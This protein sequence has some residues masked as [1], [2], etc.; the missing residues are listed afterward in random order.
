M[1]VELALVPLVAIVSV[2]EGPAPAPDVVRH[3]GEGLQAAVRAAVARHGELVFRASESGLSVLVE[4]KRRSV[5]GQWVFGGA[6]ATTTRRPTS[7]MPLLFLART[8]GGRWVISLEG[9]R[10][11][12]TAVRNA[13]PRLLN[14]WESVVLAATHTG[15]GASTRLALPWR[16]GDSWRHS[17][18][19]GNSGDS[20]PFNAID[21]YGGDGRVRAAGP[22]LVYQFCTN[23]R[24]PYLKIV[25]PNGLVTGYYHLRDTTE[26]ADGAVVRAGEYLGRIGSE[27]PCGGHAT[28]DHVHWSLWRGGQPLA[29]HGRNIGGWTWYEGSVSYQGFARRG[30]ARVERGE[31]CVTNVGG[32]TA[33][34]S[35]DPLLCLPSRC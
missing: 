27:V 13:P 35:A 19:H 6:V 30:D 12:S 4:P 28:G 7:P 10:D 15:L 8:A 29:V 3:P 20:R 9:D 34:V 23:A 32:R 18:V 25:H 17:G 33:E 24:W 1:F 26:K 31:C 21:F 5:D 22:G 16:R 14:R 11:F 2:L